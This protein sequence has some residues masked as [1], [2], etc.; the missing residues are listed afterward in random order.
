MYLTLISQLYH[1]LLEDNDYVLHFANVKTQRTKWEMVKA[2]ST[3][4]KSIRVMKRISESAGVCFCCCCFLSWC[5]NI[6]N[7][8]NL[9]AQLSN[10]EHHDHWGWCVTTGHQACPSRILGWGF[11]IYVFTKSIK[12]F[13]LWKWKTILWEILL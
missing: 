6:F 12:W 11:G 9:K 4:N 8:T 10:L 2:V 5:G 3:M 13:C 7:E 1:K